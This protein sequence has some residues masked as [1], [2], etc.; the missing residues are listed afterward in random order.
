MTEFF[1][2]ATHCGQVPIDYTVEFSFKSYEEN[3]SIIFILQIRKLRPRKVRDFPEVTQPVCGEMGSC[4]RVVRGQTYLVSTT[5]QNL[6]SGLRPGLGYSQENEAPRV[7]GQ[8]TWNLAWVLPL[9]SPHSCGV[10]TSKIGIVVP[11]LRSSGSAHEGPVRS[12]A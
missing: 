11:V 3:T 12:G 5:L 7:L 9:L 4:L 8:E 6:V 2:F 10:L 1:I